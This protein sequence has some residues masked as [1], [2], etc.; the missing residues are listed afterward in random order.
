MRRVPIARPARRAIG[1]GVAALLV[2]VAVGLIA[3]GDDQADPVASPGS[4]P[5]LAPVAERLTNVGGVYQEET[6][7]GLEDLDPAELPYPYTEPVPPEAASPIDGAYLKITPL[8]GLG[9]PAVA[10][11]IR[12]LRC[13]PFRIEAGVSTLILFHGRYFL[14]HQLSDFRSLGFFAVDGHRVTFTNDPN[15]PTTPG[16]YRWRRDGVELSLE[17]IHDPCPFDRLRARDLTAAPWTAFNHCLTRFEGLWPGEL[18][19]EKRR[20]QP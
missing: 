18:G 6:G 3:A 19:C 8:R 5:A 4:S 11:P 15:C 16:V 17:E 9:Q 12:C 7:I 10:L 14:H 20:F 1:A 2:V 13:I